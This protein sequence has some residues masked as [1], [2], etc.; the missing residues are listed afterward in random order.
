MRVSVAQ[1]GQESIHMLGVEKPQ[2]LFL[3]CDI[4]KL[5]GRD[6]LTMDKGN[7]TRNSCCCDDSAWFR[8]Y[9]D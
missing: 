7:Y 6:I 4:P 8:I 9:G 2:I 5:S 1:D 3:N